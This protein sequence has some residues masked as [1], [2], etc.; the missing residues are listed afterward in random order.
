M[1]VNDSGDDVPE[2][3]RGWDMPDYARPLSN[4][5]SSRESG[6]RPDIMQGGKETFDI[7]GPHP[8]RAGKGGTSDASGLYA[9]TSPT[10]NSV[11]GAGTPMHVP[12]QERAFWKNAYTGY[13]ANT[14][15]DLSADLQEKGLTPEIASKIDAI[16]LGYK[17]IGGNVLGNI[18]GG[19][20]IS[21]YDAL[22]LNNAP[23]YA[24]RANMPPSMRNN[25]TR[26]SMDNDQSGEGQIQYGGGQQGP[27][28]SGTS[29]GEEGNIPFQQKAEKVGLL[30]MLGVQTT[31]AERLALIKA[32]GAMMGTVG[33]P[34]KAMSNA[35]MTYADELT[36]QNKAQQELASAQTTS[37][38]TEGKAQQAVAG[39]QRELFKNPLGVGTSGVN[40][41]TM[42]PEVSVTDLPEA[43]NTVPVGGA[44]KQPGKIG[45]GSV[46][47]GGEGQ[48]T[49]DPDALK[50]VTPEDVAN[51][52]KASP[53]VQSA[54]QKVKD[55][56]DL[57]SIY[58]DTPENADKE[59]ILKK[60]A[61]KPSS[62]Q[63]LNWDKWQG[64]Y[65]EQKKAATNGLYAA[66]D[67]GVNL[68]T[69][70]KALANVPN[71]GPWVSGAES[72]ARYKLGNVIATSLNGLGVSDADMKKYG[73]DPAKFREL[74][75][76]LVAKTEMEKL[77]IALSRAQNPGMQVAQGWLE[78]TTNSLPTTANQPGANAALLGNLYAARAL[79]KDNYNVVTKFGAMT[80]QN[81]Y[82]NVAAAVQAANPITNYTKD[83]DI[84]AKMVDPSNKDMM[85]KYNGKNYNIVGLYT[86]HLI[87][88]KQFN[89]FAKEKFGV[90]NASRIF[91]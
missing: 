76:A 20:K 36:A 4:Y 79:A 77:G 1:P 15:R 65:D 86:D 89:E 47:V 90:H 84:V 28:R 38:E 39:S 29:R 68:A 56:F 75:D 85:V 83:A 2:K 61:A 55:N 35:I 8:G 82:G 24:L 37:K 11:A 31:P 42:K 87:T 88:A 43:G 70:A 33:N 62:K 45:S 41:K 22:K 5:V 26:S 27:S 40:P 16:W 14:G 30:G 17:D 10:W 58:D 32:G 53:K 57:G 3:L 60:L 9:F 73:I 69:Y 50:S 78:R 23:D 25:T 49:I 46:N 80:N 66:R 54:A 59:E 72:D 52:S 12:N 13:K 51:P 48:V 7:N 18:P 64:E 71:K 19:N 6:N 63:A 34:A 21:A 67:S 74:N 91:D 81:G 44:N